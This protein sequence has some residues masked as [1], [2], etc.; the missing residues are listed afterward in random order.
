[1]KKKFNK[2]YNCGLYQNRVTGKPG[3][4]TPFYI[5]KKRTYAENYEYIWENVQRRR[6]EG[7]PLM[8]GGQHKS[9]DKLNNPAYVSQ[10]NRY[11]QKRMKLRRET[12]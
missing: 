5:R 9:W 10:Q 7:D 1:M 6:R 12:I 11:K 8:L 4:T 3:G 2:A